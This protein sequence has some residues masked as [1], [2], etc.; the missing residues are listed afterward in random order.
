MRVRSLFLVLFLVVALGMGLVPWFLLRIVMTLEC[1][2]ATGPLNSGLTEQRGLAK[3]KMFKRGA[4]ILLRE[5]VDTEKLSEG[6]AESSQLPKKYVTDPKEII[7]ER[8]GDYKFQFPAGTIPF[9]PLIPLP[10]PF[11]PPTL[12]STMSNFH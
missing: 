8:V 10:L 5:A 6:I 11:H 2:I 7:T 4:T 12:S 3:E 1:S 9:Y